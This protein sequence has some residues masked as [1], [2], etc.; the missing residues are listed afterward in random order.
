MSSFRVLHLNSMLTGGGTDDQC[1]K[2]AA[3]LQELGHQI[4]VAGP[5]GRDFSSRIRDMG[6]AF[7]ATSSSGKSKSR[8][9]TSVVGMLR[10]EKIQILH[11]HHGRDYWPAILAAKLTRSGVKIVLTRHLAKSPSSWASRHFLLS[12]C[13]ALIA[14][15][16]FTARVLCKGVYEPGSP[17]AERRVRPA[18]R[19]DHSKI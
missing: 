19:G 1:A 4:V 12:R 3:G 17:E 14:V 2:L 9:I 6:V 5:D 7:A 13:N 16:E 8:L 18:L 11:A 10:R 15:S